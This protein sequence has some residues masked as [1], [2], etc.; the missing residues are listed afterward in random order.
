[1]A[2]LDR[3]RERPLEAGA[4]NDKSSNE[5]G[6]NG[7]NSCGYAPKG[8]DPV[9]GQPIARFSRD[10][11]GL[12]A[13]APGVFALRSLRR[14]PKISS[15]SATRHCVSLHSICI[16]VIHCRMRGCPFGSSATSKAPLSSCSGESL[17]TAL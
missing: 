16:T 10:C 12:R 6:R 13:D 1:M 17:H 11:N 9:D 5:G 7:A 2:Y 14:W 4:T 3:L 8:A 15:I